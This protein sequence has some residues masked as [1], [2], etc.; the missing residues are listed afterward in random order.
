[1][2]E[3]PKETVEE[4][5]EIWERESAKEQALRKEFADAGANLDSSLDMMARL[6]TVFQIMEEVLGVPEIQ[7]RIRTSINF[8]KML[9][10]N[11]EAVRSARLRMMLQQGQAG[12]QTPGGVFLPPD[13]RN[14]NGQGG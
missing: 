6:T 9:E 12:P 8:Q 4:L 10:P 3:Q 5:E 2:A 11:L 13:P 1:M 7:M 14:P